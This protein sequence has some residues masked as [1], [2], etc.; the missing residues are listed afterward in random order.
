MQH[1]NPRLSQRMTWSLTRKSKSTLWHHAFCCPALVDN[2]YSPYHLLE[3]GH[4]SVLFL[5][6]RCHLSCRAGRAED[7]GTEEPEEP[8]ADI[9]PPVDSKQERGR[10]RHKGAIEWRKSDSSSRHHRTG[11]PRDEKRG[12]GDEPLRHDRHASHHRDRVCQVTMA[13]MLS[14]QGLHPCKKLAALRMKCPA[15]SPIHNHPLNLYQEH[16][17][18]RE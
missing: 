17:L 1:Q 6:G 7:G 13:T 4:S 3:K 8:D 15:G 9:S 14:S 11:R 16:N 10:E 2:L 12:R 5:F 18:S